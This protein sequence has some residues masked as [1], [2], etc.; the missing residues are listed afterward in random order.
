MTTIYPNVLAGV[1]ASGRAF[2]AAGL[3][4]VETTTLYPQEH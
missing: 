3:Y 4:T 2:M 1:E